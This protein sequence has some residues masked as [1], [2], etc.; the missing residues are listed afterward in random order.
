M[1]HLPLRV[2]HDNDATYI[3]TKTHV[4][5]TAILKGPSWIIHILDPIQSLK[6]HHVYRIYQ[7]N[8]ESI[9]GLSLVCCCWCIER[10]DEV[11]NKG[12]LS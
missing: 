6:A 10:S 4:N 8:P 12:V 7:S 9:P 5:I 2:K 11:W 1:Q 3:L